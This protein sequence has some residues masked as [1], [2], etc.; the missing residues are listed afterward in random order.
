MTMNQKAEEGGGAERKAKQKEKGKG[1]ARDRLNLLFDPGSFQEF[2]KFVTHSCQEFGMQTQKFLGD[3]LI[4]GTGTVN[5][6]RIMAFSQ[7][8]TVL[9]D[10]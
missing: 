6:R 2:D 7:D 4:A 8:F 3:G 9:E 5:G 10:R 1:S